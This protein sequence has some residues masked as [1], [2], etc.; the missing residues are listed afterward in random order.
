M[1]KAEKTSSFDAVVVTIHPILQFLEKMDMGFPDVMGYYRNIVKDGH[2]EEWTD[3]GKMERD[4]KKM[5]EF[6]REEP[7]YIR[8]VN[9]VNKWKIGRFLSYVDELEGLD[10]EKLDREELMGRFVT[11]MDVYC[12]QYAVGAIPF[13]YKDSLSEWL[14]GGL[15]KKFGNPSEVLSFVT[16]P[17][18]GSFFLSQRKKVLGIMVKMEG[19]FGMEFF[20][21]EPQEM[22]AE[23]KGERELYEELVEHARKFHWIDN[24]YRRAKL[25]GPLDFLVKMRDEALSFS[26]PKEEL[27]AI[28]RKQGEIAEKKKEY[29]P[30]LDGEEK[31]MAEFLDVGTVIQDDRKRCNLIGD[32]VIFKFVGEISR[33]SGVDAELL[34]NATLFELPRILYGDYDV[35]KLEGRG[36][37]WFTLSLTNKGPYIEK[38]VVEGREF[39]LGER[40]EVSEF[41]GVP[42]SAGSAK[43][44]VCIVNREE[45]FGKMKEGGILVSAMTRPEFVPLMK[46]AAGVITD[47]GGLTCH[48]AVVS[49]ELGIPCIVGTRKGTAVLKD[50]D[51]VEVDGKRGIVKIW[52]GQNKS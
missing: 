18:E 17:E 26:H 25:L 30:K 12:D 31:R 46:K 33:R 15:E 27:E 49:R 29:L 6:D 23:L 11:F 14:F 3:P 22:E 13:I 39:E 7:G 28:G 1:G 48:A 24:N 9:K 47:E 50:G 16:A 43:G 40:E 19:K 51:V 41:K 20:R 10:L 38:K 44:E 5:L 34:K 52:G 21:K 4:T 45:D 36:E 35:S 32:Y 37:R 42:A 2:T 8:R